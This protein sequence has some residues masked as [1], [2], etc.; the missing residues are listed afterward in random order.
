[1]RTAIKALAVIAAVTLLWGCSGLCNSSSATDTL[2]ST[3]SWMVTYEVSITGNGTLTGIQYTDEAGATQKATP[4]GQ[5]WTKELSTVP[6]GTTVSVSAN[7]NIGNGTLLTK[8]T[9]LQ[10]GSRQ[11]SS[12][13]CSQNQ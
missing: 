7:G 3:G 6:G 13:S 10:G 4:S 12:A 9:S 1:M 2:P 5:T 11:E 8:I